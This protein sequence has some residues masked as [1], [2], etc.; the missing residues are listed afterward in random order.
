MT[1]VA[2]LTDAFSDPP[3][4]TL[5]FPGYVV[6]D[7]KGSEFGAWQRGRRGDGEENPQAP[8]VRLSLECMASESTW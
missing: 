4:R 5:A 1:Y 3:R 2:N 6:A 7:G 8:S